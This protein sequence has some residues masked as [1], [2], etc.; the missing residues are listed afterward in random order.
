MTEITVT[1]TKQVASISID[2]ARG[3]VQGTV[4]VVLDAPEPDVTSV[5]ASARL[6]VR[7]IVD[8][9]PEVQAAIDTLLAAVLVWEAED[10]T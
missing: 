5:I 7:N 6:S 1:A 3:E 10:T 2:C 4:N 9:T 8:T